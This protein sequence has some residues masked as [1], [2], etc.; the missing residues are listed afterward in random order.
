[1]SSLKRIIFH[2]PRLATTSGGGETLT[3]RKI[4][5][6]NRGAF[7]VTILTRK[8]ITSPLF[9]EFRQ[10]NPHVEVIGLDTTNNLNEKNFREFLLRHDGLPLWGKDPMVDDSIRFNFFASEYYRNSACEIV[11]FS[12]L[13]DLFGLD[14]QCNVAF[15]I[16]GS[17]PADMAVDEAPLLSKTDKVS[18][19]SHFIRD[20]FFKSMPEGIVLPSVDIVTPGIPP[21]FFETGSIPSRDADFVFAGRLVSRKGIDLVLHALKILRINHRINPSF[22]VAGD[23]E[24]KNMLQNLCKKLGI[25]NQVEFV[26][27]LN[28]RQLIELLDCSRWFLYPVK[29]PE[30]FGIAPLES[31][32]RGV[33]AIVGVP[34]GMADYMQ[35]GVNGYVLEKCHVTSLADI[36]LRAYRNELPRDRMASNALVTAQRYTWEAFSL[37]VNRFFSEIAA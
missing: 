11:S 17:P 25:E 21:A 34:G 5:A 16:Y 29:K 24:M 2:D 13:A 3:L 33:P 28:E 10:Q 4:E 36:M 8:H 37:S 1:M 23:G 27:S 18:A 22:V 35:T 15:H 9:I 32:V 20:D 7:K 12:M 26:G 31:M 14:I 6:L 30:A 19:V